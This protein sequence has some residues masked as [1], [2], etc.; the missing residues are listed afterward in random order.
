MLTIGKTYCIVEGK[1]RVLSWDES[2]IFHES[3]GTIWK[4]LRYKQF[5]HLIIMF[6]RFCSM[7]LKDEMSYEDT[8]SALYLSNLSISPVYFSP[9]GFFNLSSICSLFSLPNCSSSVIK[10]CQ[11]ELLIPNLC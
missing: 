2:Q 4:E 3:S 6:W 5:V 11:F 1:E 8:A 9:L 10:I 7:F